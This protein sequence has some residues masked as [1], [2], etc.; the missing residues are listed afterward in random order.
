MTADAKRNFDPARNQQPHEKRDG[1]PWGSPQALQ[2]EDTWREPPGFVG[3]LSAVNQRAP[4]GPLT[5]D[6]SR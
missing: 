2:L 4:A 6:P 1:P 3:W 5:I